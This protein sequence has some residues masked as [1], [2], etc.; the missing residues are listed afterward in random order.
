MP[1]PTTRD[2]PIAIAT[3]YGL[4]V[5]MNEHPTIAENVSTE[6]TERSMPPVISTNVIPTA[7][8][9]FI[10]S[11]LSMF[12]IFPR[13]RKESENIAITAKSTRNI[14]NTRYLMRSSITLFCFF[15]AFTSVKV[16]RP[17]TGA[18]PA[19]PHLCRIQPPVLPRASR[20][21]CRSYPIFPAFP[22]KP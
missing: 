12:S 7:T 6:P 10:D 1:R 13:V 20:R 19:L 16:R 11:C 3:G 22:K 15:I 21:S 8:M 4:P 18:F 2:M 5:C 14:T 17:Q 9:P